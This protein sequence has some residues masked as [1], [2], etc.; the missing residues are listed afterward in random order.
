MCVCVLLD[1]VFVG[2]AYMPG[3]DGDD[4]IYFFFSETGTEFDFFDNT[5]VSR[6]ARVCKVKRK[7]RLFVCVCG[8][9]CTNGVQMLH[10]NSVSVQEYICFS[11][12]IV[13]M[14]ICGSCKSHVQSTFF[15]ACLVNLVQRS[16]LCVCV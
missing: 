11:R 14:D 1:P 10:S 15:H 4:E 16:S 3:S 12:F 6:I 9:H 13:F 5:I 8:T 7:M 2:S